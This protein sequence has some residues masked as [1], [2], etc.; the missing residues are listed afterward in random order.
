MEVDMSEWVGAGRRSL[1]TSHAVDRLLTDQAALFSA[2]VGQL[3][4]SR[5]G[6]GGT[7]EGF[8]GTKDKENNRF[9]LKVK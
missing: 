2:L 7:E 4:Y 1:C 8:P 3:V 5:W 6:G 9:K